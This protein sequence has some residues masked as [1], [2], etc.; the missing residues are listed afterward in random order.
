M[1]SNHRPIQYPASILKL[2]NL[3]L[4]SL[5]APNDFL[6]CKRSAQAKLMIEQFRD[7]RRV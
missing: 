5:Q 1:D 2:R 7:L 4:Q 3:L 6:S